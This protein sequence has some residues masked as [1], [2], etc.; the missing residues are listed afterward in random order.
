DNTPGNKV[1][2]NVISGN[3]SD[4]ARVQGAAARENVFQMNFVGTDKDG[5]AAVPNRGQGISLSDG[6]SR[7]LIGTDGDGVNDDMEANVVSGNKLNGVRIT[8]PAASENVIAG[9]LIG[10]NKDGDA[11]VANE[12]TGVYLLLGVSKTRIQGNVL[13]GNKKNGVLIAGNGSTENTLFGNLIGTNKNGDAAVAN[14]NAGVWVVLGATRNTIGTDGDGRNDAAEG[15]VISGNKQEGVNLDA[16]EN[17][18][19]GNK[20]GTNKAGDAAI[21]NERDGVA[22]SGSNNR[23]GTDSNNVSDDLERNVLSGNKYNGV[24]VTGN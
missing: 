23:V 1:V 20:V 12:D 10:T 21:P 6:A 9:N 8:G 15:N 7:N 22:V 16:D 4:G 18:V 13:S 11:A 3:K 19:A 14:G 5:K 2:C 17:V 24:R